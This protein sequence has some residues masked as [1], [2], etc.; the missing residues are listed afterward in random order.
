VPIET[1]SERL[2]SPEDERSSEIS[3]DYNQTSEM[4]LHLII[5]DDDLKT[6]LEDQMITDMNILPKNISLEDEVKVLRRQLLEINYA[7]VSLTISKLL[8]GK[9][10][11]LHI[12]RSLKDK[13]ALLDEAIASG[14]G[15]AILQVVLFIQSTVKK[16]IFHEILRL[17]PEAVTHYV[18][19]LGTRMK[20][21]EV[22]EIYL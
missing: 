1:K 11:S 10:V 13:E 20:L 17:R 21:G 22:S 6:I 3:Y 14:N 18:N 2:L 4:P 15:D 9:S 19:Y 5:S 12:Y 7:P 16:K 8:M